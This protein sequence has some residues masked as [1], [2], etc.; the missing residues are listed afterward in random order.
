MRAVYDAGSLHEAQLLV[1][2][3][4]E[5]GISTHVRNT[6]LHGALGELPVSVQPVVCIVND[7]DYF[8]ARAIARDFDNANHQDPG[9][10]RECGTCGEASPGNFQVCWKCRTEFAPAG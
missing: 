8:A 6:H 5:Q 10:D 3:L 7:S 9:P 2:R 4:E 1:D